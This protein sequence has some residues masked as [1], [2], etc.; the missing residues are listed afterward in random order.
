MPIP[1][2]RRDDVK[3]L[4][5]FWLYCAAIGFGVVAGIAVM[6]CVAVDGPSA[7]RHPPIAAAANLRP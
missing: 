7:W 4:W 5:L 6:I 1:L 3:R 2:I